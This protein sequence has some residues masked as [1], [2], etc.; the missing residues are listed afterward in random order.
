MAA[1]TPTARGTPSGKKL[2]DGF[3]SKITFATAPTVALWEKKV[4][5]PGLDGGDPIETTTMFNVT[6]RTMANR[7]L[8]TMTNMT[9]TAAYD[10]IC[11]TTLLGLVNV[12]TTITVKFPDGS[13][14]A[15]FGYLQKFEPGELSEGAQPEATCT[16][17]P[18]NTDTTGNEQT[19]VETDVPG[20]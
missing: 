13:T 17:V 7:Q 11:Y 8:K 16:I 1:P 20:T 15:F 14:V 18:T 9:F 2:N 19:Y 10:P 12:P 4:T 3:S 6:L 5:P